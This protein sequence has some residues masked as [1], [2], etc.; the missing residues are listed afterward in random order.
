MPEWEIVAEATQ[1]E[2]G[3]KVQKCSACGAKLA[4]EVIPAT[5][6]IGLK[7]TSN[8]DGTCYVSGI[9]TCTDTD[10]VIPSVYNGERVTS[11]GSD[12]FYDCTGLTSITIPDSVTSIG[13]YAFDSCSGL[14]SVTIGN[15]VTSIGF[16]AF[17]RCTGLTSITFN[18]TKAQWNAISKDTDWTYD[19]PVRKVICSDG[20]VLI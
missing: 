2:D 20:E 11:I 15:S 3:L 4:E 19:V 8:G 10:I 7:F 9:G 13:S 1:T 5:G 6:S 14:T 16:Y 12:A 18:G 17:V